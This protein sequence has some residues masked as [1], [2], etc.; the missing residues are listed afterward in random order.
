[1]CEAA[2]V[3]N[4]LISDNALTPRVSAAFTLNQGAETRAKLGRALLPCSGN[5]LFWFRLI[6]PQE[7]EK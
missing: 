4:K 7:R 5:K 3:S 2:S 6:L 1:M